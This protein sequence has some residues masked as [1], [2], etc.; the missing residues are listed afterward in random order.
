[1]PKKIIL[2]VSLLAVILLITSV[3]PAYASRERPVF[4]EGN[5]GKFA[6]QYFSD[7]ERKKNGVTGA[8]FTFVHGNNVIYNKGFGYADVPGQEPVDPIQTSFRIGSV[9]KLFLGTVAMQL[10]E[11]GKVDLDK[12]INQYLSSF[13]IPQTYRQPIT[14]HHLLT[15]S[16]GFDDDLNGFAEAS[17]KNRQKLGS[18]V[19]N[20][21]PDRVYPPGK[22][23]SYSNYGISLAA[24]VLQEAADNPY[25][26][27]M[28]RKVLRPLGMKTSRPYLTSD[29][30]PHLAKEYALK[31]GQYKPLPLYDNNVFPA[32]SITSTGQ[33]MARFMLAHKRSAQHKSNVLFKRSNEQMYKTQLTAHEKIPGYTYTFHEK[34][35]DG[36]RF[37]EHNG[38]MAA[39]HSYLMISPEHDFAFFYSYTSIG[40]PLPIEQDFYETFFPVQQSEE[41][42]TTVS[43]KALERYEGAYLYNRY[44]RKEFTKF[45]LLLAPPLKVKATEEGLLFTMGGKEELFRP[46]HGKLFK[47]DHN[48]YVLMDEYQKGDVEAVTYLG[49]RFEKVPWYFVSYGHHAWV[50]YTAAGTILLYFLYFLAKQ[51]VRL[52]KRT[53]QSNSL[54]DHT[55]FAMTMSFVL[56]LSG[57]LYA[58]G[59]VDTLWELTFSVPLILK[60]AML[61]P[62]LAF[63]FTGILIY[64]L[65]KCWNSHGMHLIQKAVYSLLVISSIVL[66]FILNDF[67]LAGLRY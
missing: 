55:A 21:V 29:R 43:K 20:E 62:L 1:M 26:D 9:S 59:S 65:I 41:L 40:K 32:A 54:L 2:L 49:G 53:H 27:L 23:I 4:H 28:Q 14:L 13:Q 17:Y 31:G 48:D 57:F 66:L 24:Y 33:D 46:H 64:L 15:H 52:F 60:I 39:T 36:Q 8:V 16:A 18:Y 7:T 38:D 30:I 67:N 61:M 6:E 44:A 58:A 5:I 12:D 11:E 47:S 19:K 51:I 10:A 56:F 37:L 34:L 50:I 3:T 25:A 63:V 22:V 45:Q 35:Q 42:H